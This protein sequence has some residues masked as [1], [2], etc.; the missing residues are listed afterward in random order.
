[1]CLTYRAV[2]TTAH[3]QL[4]IP[5]RWLQTPARPLSLQPKT[6][7][8]FMRAQGAPVPSLGSR[9]GAGAVPPQVRRPRC[10]PVQ[11]SPAH[12]FMPGVEYVVLG[13]ACLEGE[14]CFISPH[15]VDPQTGLCQGGRRYGTVFRRYD[16]VYGILQYF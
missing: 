11:Q 10:S 8:T 12:A 9:S 3:Q 4:R 2:R 6:T 14:S 7:N 13:E 15:R 5:A 1:M 16:T